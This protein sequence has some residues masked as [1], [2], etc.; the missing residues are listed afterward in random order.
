MSSEYGATNVP[1]GT[2]KKGFNVY[3]GRNFTGLQKP[4]YKRSRNNPECRG[5]GK[6][7]R[8]EQINKDIFTA[9]G[10]TNVG[11]HRDLCCESLG[12]GFFGTDYKS[13]CGN[14]EFKGSGNGYDSD[15]RAGWISSFKVPVGMYLG[16]S[17]SGPE[18][19]C[20]GHTK[21]YGWGH[22]S[23]YNKNLP[24]DVATG[25]AGGWNMGQEQFPETVNNYT[26]K[27]TANKDAKSNKC[28]V[29]VDPSPYENNVGCTR[30]GVNKEI[31][32]QMGDYALNQSLCK[33]TC[34]DARKEG[35]GTWWCKN[36][37]DRLCAGVPGE[38]LKRDNNGNL[39]KVG[40]QPLFNNSMCI[41]YCG[42]A[43]SSTCRDIKTKACSQNGPEAWLNDP[44]VA[45]YC[46]IY[47]KNNPNSIAMSKVCKDVMKDQS[48]GQSVFS[49]KGCGYLCRGGV[50]DV[51]K[52]WCRDRRKDYCTHSV[53]QMLTKDCAEFCEKDP[54]ACENF[55]SQM[56]KDFNIKTED[57]LKKPVPPTGYDIAHWCGCMMP[58]TY[59]R[60]KIEENFDRLR[61]F[62]YDVTVA[63]GLDREPECS[64]PLCVEGSIMTD[65]QRRNK[66]NQ[67]CK[68]CVQIML[69]K[70][71]DSTIIDGNVSG[72]QDGNCVKIK[73]I[74][75]K[76]GDPLP[77]GIYRLAD[78][79]NYYHVK[80]NG[81]YC[82][83]QSLVEANNLAQKLGGTIETVDKIPLSNAFS[84]NCEVVNYDASGLEVDPTT[85]E[86]NITEEDTDVGAIVGGIIGVLAVIGVG[87]A[88]GIAVKN[89]KNS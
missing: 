51:D 66:E 4:D 39:V 70:F 2:I 7:C 60:E 5:D 44:K 17:G 41:N 79:V 58:S 65:S 10:K 8:G 48:S 6:S 27:N 52:V 88:I 35:D 62:G 13:N 75:E 47:W 77:P 69:Q 19:T 86:E 1:A 55:L 26:F 20:G 72:S 54:E 71:T 32:C 28:W 87:V 80:E 49:D 78:T 36:A 21:Y 11:K 3:S 34:K 68:Q 89:K 14:C 42:S 24:F 83:I 46:N 9:D 81:T 43:E 25:C 16:V 33:D 76:N 37:L 59:Y 67:R 56:C 29:G 30:A 40:K 64:Y 50:S 82:K 18:A 84:G 38:P 12:G 15:A 74:E 23:T 31:F 61:D 53:D 85:E 73:K 22:G 45:P 57:D 63:A